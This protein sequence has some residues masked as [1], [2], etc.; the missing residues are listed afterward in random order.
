MCA[1]SERGGILIFDSDVLI[2]FLHGNENAQNKVLSEAPFK[3]SAVT[4]MELVQGMKDKK[5]LA[6]LKKV[7][8]KLDVEIIQIE[9]GISETAISYVEDFYLSNSL[10]MGDALI[11]ATCIKYEEPLC[12]ANDK[13][14][15]VVNN[16]K[17]DVF[18]P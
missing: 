7:M 12:T 1:S 16:L 8:K 4:Y 2:W 18:R 9:R 3:I 11:A 14:Y 5:E 17:L 6:A 15:K 13:H 10:E